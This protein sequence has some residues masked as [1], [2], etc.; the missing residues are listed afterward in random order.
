MPVN[1]IPGDVIEGSTGFAA[2]S[3]MRRIAEA[4]T[5]V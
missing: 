4:E 5:A 1:S 2:A 3:E